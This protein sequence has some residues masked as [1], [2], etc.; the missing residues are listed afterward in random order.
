MFLVNILLVF[1]NLLTLIKLNEFYKQKIN[2]INIFSFVWLLLLIG[3][4]LMPFNNYKILS[5]TYLVLIA[6]WSF[7]LIFSFPFYRGKYNDGFNNEKYNLKNLKIVL[8]VLLLLSFFAYLLNISDIFNSITSLESWASKR[9][10]Q[11]FEEVLANNLFYSIFA[12]TNSI[13]IPISFFLL[14]KKK[15]TKK[16][17][18]V[19]LLY[20]FIT[21]VIYFTRAPVLEFLI[22]T[23]ISYIYIYERVNLRSQGNYDSDWRQALTKEN[24]D[25]RKPCIV[26]HLI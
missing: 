13:I 9:K 16:H 18:I 19:V 14:K 2:H 12:R 4:T 11:A 17:L 15:I 5:E 25:Q 8:I 24:F 10:E 3:M 21:S 20:A 22:I 1:L 6:S 26:S 23:V 7:F